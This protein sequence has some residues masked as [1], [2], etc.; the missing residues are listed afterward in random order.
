MS[1]KSNSAK[2]SSGKNNKP[3][4]KV[5]K[6]TPTKKKVAT[7]KTSKTPKNLKTTKTNKKPKMVKEA[8]VKTTTTKKIK[9][10]NNTKNRV[11]LTKDV[12]IPLFIGLL[13][14]LIITISAT[15]AYFLVTTGSR[16]STSSVNTTLESV[17]SVAIRNEV[18]S[19]TLSVSAADMMKKNNDVTYYASSEGTVNEENIETLGVVSA[20]GNGTFDCE[21][22][23]VI[24][25]SGSMYT[26][27]QNMN[28]KSNGQI[29][30]TFADSTFDFNT[31]NL[32]PKRVHKYISGLSSLEDVNLTGSLKLVNKK[33][34]NQTAL[35]GTSITISFDIENFSCDIV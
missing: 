6:T 14:L 25:A 11:K 20:I 13:T 21:Y 9:L 1:N 26:A 18:N 27:F 10:N 22:D 24:T 28:D 7:T 12:Y 8:E 2:K 5:A 31:Q 3:K 34:Y 17:G 35:A 32:F 30:F 15:Y 29:E 4:T 23:V 19:L 16:S 33:N